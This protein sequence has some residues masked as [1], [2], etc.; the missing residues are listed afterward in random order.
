METMKNIYNEIMII[1]EKL[2]KE[3]KE[4]KLK[5]RIL[6]MR[7][8]KKNIIFLYTALSE[9]QQQEIDNTLRKYDRYLT[10]LHKAIT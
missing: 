2:L 3:N 7:N 4:E 10:Y 9:R 1:E 8:I 6:K 5:E